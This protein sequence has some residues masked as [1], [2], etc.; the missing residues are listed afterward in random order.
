MIPRKYCDWTKID[1]DDW[2]VLL[3]NQPQFAKHCDW[4]KLDA[5]QKQRLFGS[6][7]ELK[8]RYDK[9]KA[10]LRENSKVK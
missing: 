2:A 1:G 8:D 3:N 9:E 6:P 4:S 7:P 10:V 5:N